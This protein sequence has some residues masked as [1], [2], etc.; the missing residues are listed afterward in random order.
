M[1]M[2]ADVE[3]ARRDGGEEGRSEGQIRGLARRPGTEN[4]AKGSCHTT[5]HGPWDSLWLAGTSSEQGGYHGGF[6][7]T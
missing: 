3:A 4:D 5:D 6:A 7:T 2:T 1:K